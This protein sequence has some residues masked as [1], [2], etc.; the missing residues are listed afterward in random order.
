MLRVLWEVALSKMLKEDREALTAGLNFHFNF[1]DLKS[2]IE[3]MRANATSEQRRIRL[4]FG[5][6]NIREHFDKI[7]SWV[8]K[9]IA[10]GDTIVTYDPGH[11]ALPWAALRFILQV[12]QI[13]PLRSA[14]RGEL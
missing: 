10:I 6:I 7:V 8:Q 11:A 13:V 2:T 3:K 12:R 5:E 14:A 9:F 4:P 1:D